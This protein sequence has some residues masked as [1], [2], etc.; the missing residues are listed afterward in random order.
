MTGVSVIS[1]DREEQP[2][3]RRYIPALQGLGGFFS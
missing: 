3:G 2:A 1:V